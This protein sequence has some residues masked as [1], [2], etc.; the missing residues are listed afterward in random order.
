MA[1]ALASLQRMRALILQHRLA[2]GLARPFVWPG[3]L[4]TCSSNCRDLF[5]ID[6]EQPIVFGHQVRELPGVVIENRDVAA[7]HVGDV[8]LVPILD[9]PDQRSPM[10][11]TS[12]S[13]WGLKHM[14]LF[15]S[16]PA[17]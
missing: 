5:L 13:G 1:P 11:I 9:Q 8:G 10:L 4:E 17:G 12:S 16:R 3:R 15:A 6:A 14:T 2:V 7:G